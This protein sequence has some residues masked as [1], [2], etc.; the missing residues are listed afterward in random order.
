MRTHEWGVP[1][2]RWLNQLPTVR[3]SP[4]S[5]GAATVFLAIFFFFFTRPDD[6]GESSHRDQ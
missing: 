4:A 5:L 2:M 6:S 3:L 1:D